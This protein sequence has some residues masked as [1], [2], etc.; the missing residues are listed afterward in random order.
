[1]MQLEFKTDGRI[2][3]FVIADGTTFSVA[4]RIDKLSAVVPPAIFDELRLRVAAFLDLTGPLPIKT[5]T[6]GAR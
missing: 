6:G 5:I 3:V 4:A 2:G 1:M